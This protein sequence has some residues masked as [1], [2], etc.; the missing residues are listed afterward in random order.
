MNHA[1]TL[2]EEISHDISKPYALETWHDEIGVQDEGHFRE[3][4]EHQ[5][6]GESQGH[7]QG[8]GL[9]H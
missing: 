8:Y 5:S 4:A 1:S 7:G 3:N 6:A 9:E 2:S